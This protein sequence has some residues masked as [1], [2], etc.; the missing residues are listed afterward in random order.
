MVGIYLVISAGL[1]LFLN[2]FFDILRE[3]YSWWL[4]PLMVVCLTLC[5]ILLHFLA[6]ILMISA[7]RLDKP[8]KGTGFF[9][10]LIK[11]GLPTV[12]KLAGIN[13]ETVG[14][15]KLPE[16]GRILLLCNHQHDFDP[17][18]IFNTFPDAHLSFIGKKDIC[19]EMPFIARAMHLL[20]CLFIDRENDREAAKTIVNAIKHLKEERGSI[21]LFPEGYC[22]ADDE[23]LPFR[24]G[25]LKVAI[26]TKAPVVVCVINNTKKIIPN[27]FR[28][29]TVVDFR[30]LDVIR[31]EEYENMN[32][33]ELGDIIHNKMKVAL[34]DIRK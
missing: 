3:P 27:M 23:L 33:A 29:T 20:E 11:T 16:Q 31:P 5:F 25:S 10:F 2:N 19:D 13:V 17:V 7:T 4:V 26:K 6:V 8:P 24:N 34:D 30:I 18:I 1:T 12:L 22:S 15:E 9:R 32:T 21:A 28:K 14:T